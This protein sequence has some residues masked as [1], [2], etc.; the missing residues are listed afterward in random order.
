VGIVSSVVAICLGIAGLATVTGRVLDQNGQPIAGTRVFMEAGLVADLEEGNVGPDGS[1]SFSDIPQGL[2]GIIAFADGHAFGGASIDVKSTDEPQPV[3]IRLGMPD[4]LV[5]TTEDPRGKALEGAIITRVGLL[6]S[7]SKV[8]IP[9]AKLKPFGFVVP[10]SD[11]SGHFNVPNLPQGATV[12]LKVVHPRFAQ[13]YKDGIAVGEKGLQIK[14]PEGVLVSGEVFALK[15]GLA[16]ANA[17]VMFRNGQTGDTAVVRTDSRGAYSLKLKP[18]VYGFQGSSAKH[19]S[20]G[21][22]TITITGEQLTMSI[23]VNVTGLGTIRG[24][25]KDAN[26]QRPIEHA[27]LSLKAGGAEAARVET[28][29]SGDFEIYAAE[30]ENYLIFDSAQGYLPPENTTLRINMFEDKSIDLPP[31]LVSAIPACTVEVIDENQ[32]PVPGA[33]VTLLQPSQFGW[34]AADRDGRAKISF[35]A[36]PAG[37]HVVGFVEHPSRPSGALFTF[38]ANQ[39]QTARVQLLPLASVS[40]NVLGSGNRPIKGAQVGAFFA[41]D[42]TAAP[43]LLWKTLSS[44]DGHFEWPCVAAQA[45][46]KCVVTLG[47]QQSAESDSAILQEGVSHDLGAIT[48][49]YWTRG[50][51]ALGETLEWDA[52]K[53]L[54]GPDVN[55]SDASGLVVIYSSVINAATA[56]ETATNAHKILGSAAPQFAVVVNGD[57]S[58]VGA[59]VPVYRGK[60]LSGATVCV[61]DTSGKVTLEAFNLPPLV[62]IQRVA[63]NRTL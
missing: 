26:T 11:A 37:S 10:V 4:S 40:G 44:E 50:V 36:I 25:V 43:V 8:G 31:F 33:V 53:H 17:D 34:Y 16:V 52:K 22:E 47:A 51:S 59:T 54:A 45:P 23:R 3:T 14:L 29:P 39:E 63:G 28:G 15:Q 19:R 60:P 6:S 38:D 35:T 21:W 41:D 20:P 18:G 13:E 49:G 62:A 24:S 42:R 5:G 57:F 56:I 32:S 7:T 55:T 9:F 61:A 46:F 30:G 2:I 27:K 12:A 1:F 48:V 58:P